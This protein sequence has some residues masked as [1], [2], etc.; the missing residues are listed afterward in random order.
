MENRTTRDARIPLTEVQRLE[1]SI[2]HL[3][4]T[5][6][7]QQSILEG[8]D[9]KLKYLISQTDINPIIVK[10]LYEQLETKRIEKDKLSKNFLR[11]ALV[12]GFV[13]LEGIFILNLMNLSPSAINIIKKHNVLVICAIIFILILLIV[14][15]FDKNE[16]DDMDIDSRIS[17][18][19]FQNKL[20]VSF[21]QLSQLI[22]QYDEA[23]IEESNPQYDD[24][25]KDRIEHY[26]IKLKLAED[27]LRIALI[28][29]TETTN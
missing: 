22:K 3:K 18:L 21:E 23:V 11:M 9:N 28:M 13:F 27:K 20:D 16:I 24:R 7:V 5:I 17:S 2:S 19:V 1:A 6:R 29:E 26:N 15:L 12:L 14:R 10:E 4:E 8:N 25:I